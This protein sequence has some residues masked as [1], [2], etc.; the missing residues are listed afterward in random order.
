[1]TPLSSE[2]MSGAGT[3]FERR[4]KMNPR[5]GRAIEILA[6]AIDYLVD[7]HAHEGSLIVWEK[8]HFEAVEILKALNRQIYLECPIVPSFEERCS[9][10][11][12]GKRG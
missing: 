1:M 9:S 12:F 6:H 4:R 8:G 11:F 7:M 3:P 5:A 10:F 2:N